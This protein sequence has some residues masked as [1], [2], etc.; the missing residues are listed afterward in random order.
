MA[1]ESKEQE[2]SFEKLLFL[3]HLGL[4]TFDFLVGIISNTNRSP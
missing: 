4:L 2:F 1:N 3:S